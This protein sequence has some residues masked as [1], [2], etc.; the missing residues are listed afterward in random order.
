MDLS[1]DQLYDFFKQHPEK[2]WHLQELQ[3]QL[4]LSTRSPLRQ[5][6][7]DLIDEGKL[8][9]TRRRTYGLPQEMNLMLGRLQ[10]TS[11]GYGFVISEKEGEK[12]LF[13]PVDALA[14]AWDGDRVVARPNSSKNDN[15]RISGEIVRILKRKYDRVVGTLEYSKGYAILRPDSPKLRERVLLLPDSVGKLP[16]GSRIVGKMAWPEVTGEREPFAEVEEVLGGEA[17]PETETRAVVIKYDLKDSFDEATLKEAEAVPPT[18]TGEMMAGRTDL[19][20]I[21]TFTV[22]GVDAKDFDDAISLERLSGRG[23][24]GVLRVG[25]HIADVSYY[26][27]E[28]T[29]LDREAL[30]RATSV[31]LPGKVLPMLPEQLSNGICSLVEGEPRLALSALVDISREGEVKSVKFKETVIQSDA[32][33]TYDQVQQFVN[34]DERL[35]KGKSKLERDVKVLVDLTQSL[36][37]KRLENGALDFDFTEAKVDVTEEGALELTPVKSNAARQLIEELMLL[38]NRLVAQELSKR[39][40]PALYRIHEDPSDEKILNLQRSLGRLGYTFEKAEASP[41]DLQDIIR[42]AAGKPEAQLV[43]TLLLRSLKQAR[44]SADN[45]GHFGLAFDYYLH[46]TSPIRRYPD[47]VVHRVLRAMLQRRLSPTLKERLKSD[48]PALAEHTSERER[49]AEDAER[50]LTRYYHARWAKDHVGEKFAGVISGVTNFGVFVALPNAV[51]GLIHVSQLDDDY[52]VYLED[53]L[54]LLGKHSRRKFRLGD[55]LEVK[56]LASNPVQRQIDLIPGYA[57]MP[58]AEPEERERERT[59]PPKELKTPLS[60]KTHPLEDERAEQNAGALLDSDSEAANGGSEKAPETRASAKPAKTET[61]IT[62]AA[63]ADR[64]RETAAKVNQPTGPAKA[65]E[66]E[67]QP[68][69]STPRTSG[70]KRVLVFGDPNRRK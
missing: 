1:K 66:A 2:P 14:G 10:I 69:P 61:A 34:G 44:Y 30:E 28:G 56:I 51:E 6:L 62:K 17:D 46:F 32:R 24:T 45:L 25:V 4:K 27:A 5:V 11:G 18:V 36:R 54:M 38:A 26:V 60:R 20:G 50:D 52:Y 48:F 47:L 40:I 55:R 35:P 3:N 43:N 19:R 22:D 58:E 13:I 65:T 29:S 70:R 9:R 33:L 23:K 67:R 59:K 12:D 37:Q 68:A 7:T 21:N 64:P 39:D 53:S 31:Y 8:I 42:Q 63:R 57:D 41:Q 15:G 49:T 16:A